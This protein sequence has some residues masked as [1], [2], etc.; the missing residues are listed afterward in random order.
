MISC[1]D[2]VPCVSHTTEGRPCILEIFTGRLFNNPSHRLTQIKRK[3]PF[4]DVRTTNNIKALGLEGD[5]FRVAGAFVHFR[6]P[7][8]GASQAVATWRGKNL[9]M[10]TGRDLTAQISPTS[11]L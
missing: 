2:P 11:G 9:F 7:A 10:K 1:R 3:A 8:E 6:V 5:D 4:A